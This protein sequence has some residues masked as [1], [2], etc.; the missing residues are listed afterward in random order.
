MNEGEIAF[1]SRVGSVCIKCAQSTEG[2]VLFFLFTKKGEKWNKFEEK[3]LARR[4]Q[5]H[6]TQ[7][8]EMEIQKKQQFSRLCTA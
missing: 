6:Q 2:S 1:A 5:T 4:N 3:T 8:R 7:I